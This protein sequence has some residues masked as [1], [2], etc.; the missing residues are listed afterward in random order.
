[1]L[2]AQCEEHQTNPQATEIQ[3]EHYG[4]SQREYTKHDINVLEQLRE[5]WKTMTPETVVQINRYEIMKK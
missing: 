5:E 4:K 1:M 3:L 2:D